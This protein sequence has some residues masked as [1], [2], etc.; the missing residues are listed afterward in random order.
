M[1]TNEEV[2]PAADAA[3]VD[4]ENVDEACYRR[5]ALRRAADKSKPA[6]FA[7]ESAKRSIIFRSANKWRRAVLWTAANWEHCRDPRHLDV[8]PTNPKAGFVVSRQL[9]N[10]FGE[11]VLRRARRSGEVG[12]RLWPLIIEKCASGFLQDVATVRSEFLELLG[13]CGAVSIPKDK[14][15]RPQCVLVVPPG[16][17]EYPR[18]FIDKCFKKSGKQFFFLCVQYGRGRDLT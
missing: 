5:R 9:M 16:L 2:Q 13:A 12:Q 17:V 10:N 18:Q 11:Y 3:D 1:W 6:G 14:S 7:M 15:N 4:K 8:D